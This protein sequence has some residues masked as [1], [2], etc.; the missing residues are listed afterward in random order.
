MRPAVSFVWRWCILWPL[1]RAA[2]AAAVLIV[3]ALL[4][5]AIAI[6]GAVGA[7]ALLV[8]ALV[9]VLI[10]AVLAVL[11][12]VV[13]MLLP[14]SKVKEIVTAVKERGADE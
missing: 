10:A 11:A 7:S 5:A 14:A 1:T 3:G 12:A 6:V 9:A 4:V 2:W 13:P 8:A